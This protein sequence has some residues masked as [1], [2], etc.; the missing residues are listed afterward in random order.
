MTLNGG[1]WLTIREAAELSGYNSEYIRRLIREGVIAARKFSIV[2]QVSQE[3]LL[4][5]LDK[6]HTSVDGR[7]G[8]KT[9]YSPRR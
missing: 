8:P 6:A 9:D 7:R 1:N 5:F 3:S 2:W 4:A